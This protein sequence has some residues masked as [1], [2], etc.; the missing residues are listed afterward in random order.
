MEYLS[1]LDRDE[2]EFIGMWQETMQDV[3]VSLEAFSFSPFH[4][5]GN[6]TPYASLWNGCGPRV[7]GFAWETAFQDR[8]IE[9]GIVGY[10]ED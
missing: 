3:E 9:R 5:Y 10:N 8:L 4:Y 6:T 1:A 7:A 2:E